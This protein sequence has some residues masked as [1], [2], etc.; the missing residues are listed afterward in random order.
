MFFECRDKFDSA[1]KLVNNL[2]DFAE[3][4]RRDDMK[5]QSK[6]FRLGKSSITK[7]APLSDLEQSKETV[8]KT[9]QIGYDIISA[10]RDDRDALLNARFH[11][12]ETDRST[13]EAGEVLLLID[14][15]I[16]V[17]AIL[18][19]LLI[20]VLFLIILLLSYFKLEKKFY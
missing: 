6:W 12:I 4:A 14:R 17:H 11:I 5:K 18:L 20:S 3:F 8:R 16:N 10:L 15:R 19:K 9:E 2:K 7:E 13:S 1:A